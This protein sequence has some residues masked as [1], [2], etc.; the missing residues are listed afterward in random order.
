VGVLVQAGI[1]AG[2]ALAVIVALWVI[3]I[4]TGFALLQHPPQKTP[5]SPPP[6]FFA[7]GIALREGILIG[8]L[9]GTAAGL[10]AATRN[11]NFY[12]ILVSIWAVSQATP[13]AS[14]ER[15]IKRAIGV[16]AGC[17]AIGGL[18]QVA[19]ADTVV[20]V[21]FIALFAGLVWWMRNYTIYIAGVTM[22]TVAL[23]GDLGYQGTSF[24]HWALLRLADTLIGI[25]IGFAAYRLVVT[26]PEIRRARRDGTAR[27][28]APPPN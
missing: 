2:A 19:S 28:G 13:D 4:T 8:A 11:H 27:P 1:G 25:A 21:G 5:A 15:G 22:M 17:I 26:E 18:A 14:F 24:L 20:T 12:W 10:Y 3:R 9:L 16:M 7:R 6:P 23:H